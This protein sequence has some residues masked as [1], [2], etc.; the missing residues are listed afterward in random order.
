MVR[1][2]DRVFKLLAANRK[3]I[4][5]YGVRRLGLFGSLARGQ[6]RPTSDIDL[7]VEFEKKTFDAYMGLKLF[8]EELFGCRVDLVLPSAIKPRL[9]DAILREVAYVPGL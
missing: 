1:S 8:L 7:L 9:R 6:G 5:G 2:R 4:R 3:A